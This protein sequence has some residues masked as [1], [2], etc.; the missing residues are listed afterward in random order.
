MRSMNTNLR[1]LPKR[2]ASV[3][4]AALLIAAPHWVNAQ[5]ETS[6]RDN[7]RD[8]AE[9]QE[10]L[11]GWWTEAAKTRDERLAWWRDARFGCFIHWGVYSDLGGEYKGKRGG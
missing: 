6:R 5:D 10:A 4:F 3:V 7:P 2:L 1:A 8:E 9:A 11:K